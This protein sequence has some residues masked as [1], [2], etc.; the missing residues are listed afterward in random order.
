M[1]QIVADPD[2]LNGIAFDRILITTMG[3]RESALQKIMQ[4]EIAAESVIEIN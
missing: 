4:N 3:S 1:R 2:H